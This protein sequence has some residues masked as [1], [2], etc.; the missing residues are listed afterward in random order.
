MKL[1][2]PLAVLAAAALACGTVT[3][4]SAASVVHHDAVQDVRSMPADSMSNATT[5]APTQAESDVRTTRTTHGARNLRM[6][7]SFRELTR[8]GD[9]TLHVFEIVTNEGVRREVDVEAGPGAWIGRTHFTDARGRSH[10]CAVTRFIDYDNNRVTV[11]VPRS[12]LSQPRWVRVGMGEARVDNKI[13][14]ADDASANSRVGDDLV[15]G[16]RVRRG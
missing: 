6:V 15:L 10:K 14:Y 12:C 9:W 7:M 4:A 1:R 3:T 16:P 13:A 5:A 8:T 11:T 2:L